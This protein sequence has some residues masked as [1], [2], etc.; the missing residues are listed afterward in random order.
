MRTYQSKR[1]SRGY[2]YGFAISGIA[3][4][5]MIIFHIVLD[6]LVQRKPI[7]VN[8]NLAEFEPS[9]VGADSLLQ[10]MKSDLHETDNKLLKMKLLEEAR[11]TL[12]TQ[13]DN[14]IAEEKTSLVLH[15]SAKLPTE[16][17]SV[18]V[19]K[20]MENLFTS[21]VFE[22]K[23]ISIQDMYDD[24]LF[25]FEQDDSIPGAYNTTFTPKE[26]ISLHSNYFDRKD[27]LKFLGFKPGVFKP[28]PKQPAVRGYKKV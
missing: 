28:S 2:R 9:E 7:S 14:L 12:K 26:R 3:A 16:V 1:S 23:H 11:K 24:N 25:I 15:I 21:Y 18:V 17:G 13:R 8:K 20:D 6:F 4:W 22:K 10:K 27:L 19:E 5:F